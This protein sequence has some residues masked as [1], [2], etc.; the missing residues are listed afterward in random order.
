MPKGDRRVRPL[1]GLAPVWRKAPFVLLRYPGLFVALAVGA[2]LLS[3]A[4]VSYPLFISA[5]AGDLV[6]AEIQETLVTRWGAGVTYR[7]D[8]APLQLEAP[9]G[10]G[11]TA[12]AHEMRDALFRREMSGN[13]YLGETVATVLGDNVSVSAA[14]GSGQFRI[15]KLFAGQD[16]LRHVRVIEGRDGDGVWLPDLIA[17]ALRLGPGDPIELSDGGVSIETTVDGVYEALYS[18]PQGG[19]WL[20]WYDDIYT[21][22]ADCSPPPQ[23]VLVDHDQFHGF[24]RELGVD[25][26]SFVWTAPLA[27]G[28]RMTLDEARELEGFVEE[29][30][31]RI[32]E[33]GTLMGRVFDCCQVFALF[34][35]VGSQLFS[36][37]GNVVDAV[38]ERL[39]AVEAP[40]LV[41]RVAGIVVSL[42]VLAAAGIFAHSARKIEAGL[43]FARGV[44]ASSV[45]LKAG[46]EAIIPAL[47]GGIAGFG[48]A[49][50]LVRTVGPGGPLSASSVGSAV[51]GGG[52]AVGGA[53]VAIGGVS[54]AAFVMEHHRARLGFLARVPWEVVLLAVAFFCYRQFGSDGALVSEPGLE[55]RRPSPFLLLFPIAFIGGFAAVAARM[56]RLGFRRL[57][58]SGRRLPH[59]AYLGVHRLAAAPGLILALVAAVGMSVGT[60][61]QARMLERSLEATVEAKAGVFVG[62]DVQAWVT[63]D[64][65]VPEDFPLPVTKVVRLAH[66]GQAD[67][68]GSFDLLAIDPGTLPRA[69]FWRNEFS[70]RSLEDIVAAVATQGRG[71]LPVVLAGAEG[72]GPT[73]LDIGERRLPVRVALRTEAFPGMLAGRP[74]VVADTEAIARAFAD[75]AGPLDGSNA[76]T[77]LWVRGDPRL[78]VQALFGLEEEPFGVVTADRVEDIPYIAAVVDTFVVLNALGLGT[79]VLVVA[80]LLMY[81]EARQR[82]QAV[83]HGLSLRMGMTPGGHRRSLALELGSMLLVSFLAAVVLAVAAVLLMVPHLDPLPRIPP[84]L[85]LD[86]PAASI[87]A[88]FAVLIAAAWLGAWVAER[89]ARAIPLGEVMRVAE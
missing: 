72:P 44:G 65:S 10:R 67:P 7:A 78:A 77:E 49:L 36:F 50:L 12:P 68:I 57:G 42:A 32:S 22:C 64:I 18:R 59:S 17:D 28:L 81:L 23:F 76:R 51:R 11:G 3:L 54:A 34:R 29:F 40:G 55:I 84:T 66:A 16:V 4:A 5:T 38:E 9:D 58:E 19:Y 24:S 37:V 30:R 26:A 74:L 75:S 87:A 61:V 41:L 1:G 88:A 45:G 33:P 13:A 39:A 31:A 27:R 79:G 6:E 47:L 60:F 35:R 46:V 63:P 14:E 43:L 56:L 62:S 15:G 53:L 71:S 2:L 69:A 73:S 21:D 25:R 80:S 20:K 83:A 89:R 8:Q 85:L 86:A 82:S 48:L 70:D 52:L